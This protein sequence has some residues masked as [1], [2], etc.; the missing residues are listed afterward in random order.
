MNINHRINNKIATF[1]KKYNVYAKTFYKRDSVVFGLF[2]RF[3]PPN[4]GVASYVGYDS[5][6]RKR[7]G[8]PIDT[9]W[10]AL[11]KFNGKYSGEIGKFVFEDR[12]DC[13]NAID[14]LYRLKFNKLG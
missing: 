7:I 3:N 10:S 6:I 12:N 5:A 4:N 9:F 14:Y 13:L 11:K 1:K 2:L 8:L